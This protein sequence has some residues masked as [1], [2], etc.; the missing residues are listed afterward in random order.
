[1]DMDDRAKTSTQI[2]DAVRQAINELPS[3]NSTPMQDLQD[4]I[5]ALRVLADRG[6]ISLD[7]VDLLTV[8]LKSSY[9]CIER[10]KLGLPLEMIKDSKYGINI[11]KPI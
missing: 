7:D 1:M 10:C 9:N 8:G 2:R 4:Q 11:I 6:V 3:H 5:D